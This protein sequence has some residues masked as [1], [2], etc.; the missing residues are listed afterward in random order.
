MKKES[1]ENV[2]VHDRDSEYFFFGNQLGDEK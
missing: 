2:G 1:V